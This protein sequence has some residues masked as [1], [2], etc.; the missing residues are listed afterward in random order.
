M[1]PK[2]DNPNYINSLDKSNVLSSI[3]KLAWQL[4]QTYDDL[5]PLT[6]PPDYR[7]IN[8]VVLNGMGGSRLGGRVA[9]KLFEDKINLPIIP[10]GSYRLPKFV[11][12]K[13]LLI[14]S[15][16]SGN[17]EEIVLSAQNALKTKA[18]ILVHSQG[19]KLSQMAK[20][21]NWPGYI[22]FDPQFNPCNQP[23]MSIGYQ[24]MGI[25]LLL[26][27]CGLLTFE[28]SQMKSLFEFIKKTK[29]KY[30]FKVD[31]NKNMAK[32]LA[33]K[34]HS[35]IPI[36]AGSE[37]LTGALHVWR[38]QT[39]ENAKQLAFYFDIPEL[40]HHLLEGMKY[41]ES[42]KKNLIIIFLKS[43]LYHKRNAIRFDITR[44]IFKDYKIPT[45]TVNLEGKSQIEQV[46]ETIQLGSFVGFYLAMLNKLDP[47]PIPYVDFFKKELKKAG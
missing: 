39:N 25:I 9:E 44:E 27:K 21:N 1:K 18:K 10:I 14:L 42:N 30:D 36:L 16:Y 12:E 8:K 46:F 23:R 29:D 47:T 35:K 34:I 19:G 2:L 28:K 26:S 45:Y 43:K 33:I 40:N 22:Y 4:K 38:N 41:P 37:F 6:L 11:D 32:K 17:T 24:I 7:K 5:N 13:T 15:S 3:Q 20:A 31:Q